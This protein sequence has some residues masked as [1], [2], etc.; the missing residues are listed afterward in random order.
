MSTRA[1][2]PAYLRDQLITCLGNKRALLDFVLGTV[3]QVRERLGGRKLRAADLFA[4][5][6]VVSRG[7]RAHC[8]YLA[9]ND[10]EAYAAAAGRCY[11]AS[12]EEATK[13]ELAAAHARLTAQLA[14]HAWLTG[15]VAELYAP[16][17]DQHVQPGER[18]FYT[19]RNARYLDTARQLLAKEPPELQPYLLGPLLAMASVHA[20]TS[21][22]F[23]GFYKN[24]QTGLG[25]FGGQGNDA[26]A[27]ICADIHLPLPVWSRFAL[28]AEVTQRE[29]NALAAEL[30]PVDLVYLDPPYNQ[31]PY[32]SN[33]FLLN[34]LVDYQRPAQVSQVSGIP[35]NWQRSRYNQRAHCGP[36]LAELVATVRARFVL[37]SYSSEGF[38]TEETLLQLLAQ[39]GRVEV[40][41]QRYPA[42]RGSRNLHAR[43]KHLRELLFLVDKG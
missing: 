14:T 4:G 10:L 6:G 42:F 27:R 41:A 37:V 15:F 39:T 40:L 28:T 18:C 9:S 26:L 16:A 22:V 35:P 31:H 12:P 8:S 3:I 21:G 19:T 7:L 33:Y 24:P 34:L 29:A 23:K 20:N 13:A 36:A 11:L 43:P 25:Q 1:E 32:G 30:E 2:N 38:L 5:S 17:D